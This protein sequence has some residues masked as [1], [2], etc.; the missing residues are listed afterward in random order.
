MNSRDVAE[1]AELTIAP[2][3]RASMQWES[4]FYVS[5]IDTNMYHGYFV[6]ADPIRKY[7]HMTPDSTIKFL[8]IYHILVMLLKILVGPL[9]GDLWC[10]LSLLRYWNS[11]LDLSGGLQIHHLVIKQVSF[12]LQVLQVVRQLVG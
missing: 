8:K 10:I 6:V 7:H 11:G 9:F 3:I 1:T 12:W 2:N 5:V 4:P